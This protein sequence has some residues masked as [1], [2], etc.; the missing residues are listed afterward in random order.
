MIRPVLS[1]AADMLRPYGHWLLWCMVVW[2]AARVM[3][4]GAQLIW[5]FNHPSHPM[6]YQTYTPPSA[7]L[8]IVANGSWHRTTAD[9]DQSDL[10]RTQLPLHI[11]G[12]LRG[13]PLSRSVI[14]LETPQGPEVAMRGDALL[15]EVDLIDITAQGLV[16]NNR[17]RHELL[18][19]PS[20][21][22]T[23]TPNA[24]TKAEPTPSSGR[25]TGGIP[26]ERAKWPEQALSTQFGEDYLDQLLAQP[27]L[28]LPQ[29][30]AIPITHDGTLSGY[31]LRPGSDGTLFDA[32]PFHSGDVITA[33]AGHAVD[34]LSL[35]QLRAAFEDTSE[36]RV[37]LQR[38]GQPVML[39]LELS[40]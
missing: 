40:P 22:P 12:V 4:G 29:M 17:R 20:G 1:S 2:L 3:A 24:V 6:A 28:L 27:T 33:I 39:V 10:P 18:P 25:P 16:L 9:Q 8:P 14:V 15:D 34:E 7:A 36:V 35:D 37:K 19:W 21:E 30:Q 31:R 26:I 11:V 5:E 38:D 32:L 23:A 13:I